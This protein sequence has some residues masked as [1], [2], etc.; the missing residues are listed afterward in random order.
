MYVQRRFPAPRHL[1]WSREKKHRFHSLAAKGAEVLQRRKLKRERC[2][3]KA[4]FT[5]PLGPGS[6]TSSEEGSDSA[7]CQ[8]LEGGKFQNEEVESQPSPVMLSVYSVTFTAAER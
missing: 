7:T 4:L 1:G 5:V 3:L 8:K 6:Q 2:L